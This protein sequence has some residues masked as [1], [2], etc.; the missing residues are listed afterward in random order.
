MPIYSKSF[1]YCHYRHHHHHRHHHHNHQCCYHYHLKLFVR[2]VYQVR[3]RYRNLVERKGAYSPGPSGGDIVGFDA[4]L[5]NNNRKAGCNELVAGI[6]LETASD[7]RAG[8]VIVSESSEKPDNSQDADTAS[9]AVRQR[10]DEGLLSQMS[11]LRRY[12]GQLKKEASEQ[13]LDMIRGTDVCSTLDTFAPKVFQGLRRLERRGP[14]TPS[15]YKV[16]Q[17]KGS[18]A[19]KAPLKLA[20]PICGLQYFVGISGNG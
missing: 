15:K 18:Q 14:F 2:R 4:A 1:K 16:S 8:S 17:A 13:L 20:S 7:G 19:H 9:V 10:A 6:Q 11:E 3:R 5:K 12:S